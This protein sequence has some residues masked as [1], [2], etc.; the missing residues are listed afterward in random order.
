MATA[1]PPKR[2]GEFWDETKLAIILAEIQTLRDQIILSGGWAWHMMTPVNHIEFKHAHDHKDVDIF[3]KP[4]DFSQLVI[5]LK[6]RGYQKTW[7][8]F[9]RLPGSETFLRYTKIVQL[10]EQTVKV[11]LDLFIGD[12]PCIQVGNFWVVEPEFLLSLYGKKHSSEGCF[13]V[14]IAR[15]LLAQGIDPVGRPEMADYQPFLS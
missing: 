3:V 10:P 11:M 7:T 2:L 4:D 8:R 9:D 1:H 12:V 5:T 6:Q 14:R 13:A 15:Q